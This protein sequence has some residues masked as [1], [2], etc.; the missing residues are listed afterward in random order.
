MTAEDK[1]K[2]KYLPENW[3]FTIKGAYKCGKT[4]V[5]GTRDYID[6]LELLLHYRDFYKKL[7]AISTTSYSKEGKQKTDDLLRNNYMTKQK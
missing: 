1:P 5:M 6:H 7:A 4:V 3:N 2:L